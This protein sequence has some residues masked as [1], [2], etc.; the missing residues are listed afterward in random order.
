MFEEMFSFNVQKTRF[1][2]AYYL[3]QILRRI[4]F[5]SMGLFMFNEDMVAPQMVSL[6]L[7]NFSMVIYIG[8]AEA[9]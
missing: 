9:C 1:Q 5:V 3:V 7:L 8:R 4:L 6:M 2:R